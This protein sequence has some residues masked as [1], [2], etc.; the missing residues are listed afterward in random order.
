M[1]SDGDGITDFDEIRRF[2]TNPYDADSDGDGIEDKKEI[3]DYTVKSKYDKKLDRTFP[4]R[5]QT[6]LSKIVEKSN[7]D[8]DDYR[9]ENDKDDNNNGINDGLEGN[10]KHLG[11]SSR[12]AT[13]WQYTSVCLP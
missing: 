7:E 8:G 2:Q 5:A 13:G 6:V 3:Y 11:C 9:K 12:L 4:D 10:E 1:D